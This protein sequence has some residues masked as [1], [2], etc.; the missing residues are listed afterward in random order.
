MNQ[1]QIIWRLNFGSSAL[2]RV[3]GRRILALGL[4]LQT[5]G[6]VLAD[7]A[8]ALADSL[9]VFRELRLALDRLYPVGTGLGASSICLLNHN[10]NLN[11]NEFYLN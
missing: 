2:A 1:I 8:C 10:T 4:L 3:L 7:G 6:P 5:T 9:L 11:L